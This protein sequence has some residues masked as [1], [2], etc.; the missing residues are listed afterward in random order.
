M[1]GYNNCNNNTWA[2]PL[3]HKKNREKIIGTAHKTKCVKYAI[4]VSIDSRSGKHCYN[5]SKTPINSN[6]QTNN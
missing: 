3:E 4:S 2:R 6:N 1:Q 5:S